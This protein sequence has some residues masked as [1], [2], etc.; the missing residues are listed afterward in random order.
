M[1]IKQLSIFVEN[2]PGRLSEITGVLAGHGI[3]LR[4]L[5]IAD[6][7][8]FGILRLIVSD[9]DKALSLCREEGMTVSVTEV[10]AVEL[11]DQ[12]GGLHKILKILSD[13]GIGV[14]Y[15]YAFVT[16]PKDAYVILRVE[17]NDKAA[18]VLQEKG[19]RLLSSEE[20][21]GL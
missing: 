12:P 18:G 15:I 7:T 2:K 14:E 6:T 20:V 21:C 11:E 19:V 4:A 13:K 16:C 1:K 17:D 10:I 5:C 8:D 9:P 3:D